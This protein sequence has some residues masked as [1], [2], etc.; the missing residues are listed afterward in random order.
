MT[1]SPHLRAGLISATL[2]V[3]AVAA[4]LMLA[5]TQIGG[6]TGYVTTSG[7]SMAPRF[8]SGDLAIVRPKAQ[9]RVGDVDRLPQQDAAPRRPAPHRRGQ[10]G[11]LRDAGRQ[12][13]L[14]RSRSPRARGRARQ[15]FGPRR[16]RRPRPAL[17]AYALHGRAAV[18]GN[19][20]GALHGRP[21]PAPPARSA[22]PARGAR[23][24]LAGNAPG[25]SRP[26]GA[27]RHAREHHLHHLRG[28]R[29]RLPGPRRARLHASGDQAGQGQDS[30]HREGQL[31]LPR[32]GVCR[33]RVSRRRREHGRSDL[34]E[35]RAPRA[36]QD[37]L[38]P[39][40][41]GTASRRRHHGGR[42]AALEPHRLE[43]HHPAR[44]PQALHGRLRGRQHDA[45]PAPAAIADPR[46]READRRD[47]RLRVQPRD[48]AAGA[49]GRDARQPAA[50]Q[51]L[52]AGAQASSSTPSSCSPPPRPRLPPARRLRTTTPPR[53]TARRAA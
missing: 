20:A 25:R 35:A 14:H 19:G 2:V 16:P 50:H 6:E 22:P 23:H 39:A 33:A 1:R 21:A 28:G 40:G 37:A 11:A 5:P 52:R 34:R 7:I 32:Q 26:S 42:P 45:R 53:P 47:R 9:Y 8:H 48:R 27:I 46:G 4:W 3:L 31:R 18:R 51:R 36:R 44:R 13:R 43:P 29:S 17:A 30:L 38:P 10:G 24:A 41:H 15:A 12:Q 49:P